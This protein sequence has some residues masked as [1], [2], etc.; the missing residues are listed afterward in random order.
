MPKKRQKTLPETTIDN[1][2]S[3]E[4]LSC[5]KSPE[6]S[7]GKIANSIESDGCS[8]FFEYMR[9]KRQKATINSKLLQIRRKM[10]DLFEENGI[11]SFS[12]NNCFALRDRNDDGSWKWVFRFDEDERDE[13]Q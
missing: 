2:R 12:S 11:R 13:F 1:D 4:I 6:F 5:E 7:E 3:E 9:L 10:E 8:L